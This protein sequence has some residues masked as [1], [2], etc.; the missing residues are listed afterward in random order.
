VLDVHL[1]EDQIQPGYP[2]V[3]PWLPAIFGLSL[4]SCVVWAQESPF[5]GLPVSKIRTLAKAGDD[6]AK[7]ALGEAYEIGRDVDP[8]PLEAARWYR[9]AALAGNLEAQFRLANIVIKGT[10]GLKQDVPS[11]IKLFETAAA[12]GHAKSQNTLALMYLNGNAVAKDEKKSFELFSKAV[13][14]KLPEA[15]NSLGLLY[16][17]GI[18]TDRSVEQ[19]FTML[20]RAADQGDGW[21]LNNLGALYE[22]GWGVPKDVQKAKLLYE[23]A[24]AK[25]IVVASQ[26]LAR[27]ATPKSASAPV[28]KLN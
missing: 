22:Q 26:N 28:P 15:E 18:G 7:M 6:D 5:E 25:G 12:Q 17:R 9:E 13:E 21:G 11:A 4:L 16:L 19:A 20:K 24:L 3:R 1:Q 10:K 8:S 2:A 23:Q 14:Q 27:L